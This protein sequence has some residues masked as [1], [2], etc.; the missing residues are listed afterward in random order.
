MPNPGADEVLV[1]K[2][3]RGRFKNLDLG[4]S[5]EIKKNRMVKVVGV[6]EAEGSSFES[7]VWCDLEVVRTSFRRDGVV[8][9]VRV[10][11]ESPAKFEA[12]QASIEGD[13]QLALNA[14]REEAYYEK[15]SSQTSGF[16]MGLGVMVSIFFS[17]GAMIGAMITM[18]AAV[19][20]R[21]REIG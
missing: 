16:V 20:N 21:Q 6:M 9:S 15:N 5:F 19:S 8:S 17:L 4:T 1:G 13:K 14:F 3:I 11:L 12:F 2:R 7:E 10:K 18:Y